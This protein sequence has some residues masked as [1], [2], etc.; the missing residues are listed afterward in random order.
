MTIAT[1]SGNGQDLAVRTG[2][3][4]IRPG[5]DMWNDKQRAALGVLGIKDATNADL[6][7]FMH[8]CQKTQLDPFSRQIYMIARREKQGDQWVAKQT[9]QVGID[10]FRVIRDRIAARLGVEVEYEDTIW[11]DEA[12]QPHDVWLREEPPT[13][14]RVVVVR[15]GHRFPGVVR[16][17]A[18]AATNRDGDMIAQWRTQ[19][20]HMIEKCAEAFA[21]RR[22][23]PNDLGGLY[24]DEE[25][26]TEPAPPQVSVHRVTAADITSGNGKPPTDTPG[27][28]ATPGTPGPGG[29]DAPEP[30]GSRQQP[31]PETRPADVGNGGS[32]ARKPL[33]KSVLGNLRNALAGLD[34]EAEG[35]DLALVSA[36][37]GR[38]VTMLEALTRA[39]ATGISERITKALNDVDGDRIGATG[40][41]WSEARLAEAERQA[42]HA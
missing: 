34:W 29:P 39:E 10:G 19:P 14:C 26:T 33:P 25:M 13:A 18:Y 4:A 38:E 35:D 36:L 30:A 32:G 27:P 16:T 3:L 28:A 22:A 2:A 41:L 31:P 15:N 40:A 11:Y 5:Q 20:E 9:I 8:Y 12:G 42:S 37:V 6:A 7:V 23:F 1:T 21:L 24:I 17:A